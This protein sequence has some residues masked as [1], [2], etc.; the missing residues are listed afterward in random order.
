MRSLLTSFALVWALAAS[1]QTVRMLVQS[2]ALAGFQYYAGTVR[3]AEMRVGDPLDLI[4][5]PD[6]PHDPNA[7]RVEWRGEKLGYLPRAENK[8]VAAELDRGGRV[9]ARI[10]ALVEDRNPWRRVRIEVF[11]VL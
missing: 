9:E 6:N 1:A 7:I 4:R 2:S 5:E 3:W 10:A 11:A 8:T